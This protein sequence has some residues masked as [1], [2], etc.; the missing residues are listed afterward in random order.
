MYPKKTGISLYGLEIGQYVG[1]T[2]P[3]PLSSYCMLVV[4][5]EDEQYVFKYVE[6][7][8][9]PFDLDDDGYVRFGEGKY[10]WCIVDYQPIDLMKVLDL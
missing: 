6:G 7:S 3:E 1:S 2:G 9:R 8:A 5:I 10:A 4:A